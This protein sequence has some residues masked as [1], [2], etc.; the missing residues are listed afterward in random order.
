[1]SVHKNRQSVSLPVGSVG[2]S[3]D[4]PIQER[5]GSQVSSHRCLLCGKV[6]A[7]KRNLQNHLNKIHAVNSN[8]TSENVS[9][10]PAGTGESSAASSADSTSGVH[11]EVPPSSPGPSTQSQ[12]PMQSSSSSACYVCGRVLAN[13]RNLKIHLQKVH[14]QVW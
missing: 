14:D 3:S 8:E 5:S 10:T 1:M 6:L 4:L 13:R 2:L 11:H 12:E 9:I 7:N